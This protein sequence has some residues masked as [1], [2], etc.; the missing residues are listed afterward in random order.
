MLN[1]AVPVEAYDPDG[2]VT[3]ETKAAMTP[4]RI[5][6]RSGAPRYSVIF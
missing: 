3:D 1:A 5:P 4:A 6:Y 2:G